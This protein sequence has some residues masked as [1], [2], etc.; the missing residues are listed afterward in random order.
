M[1]TAVASF[2]LV[3]T[4]CAHSNNY[5]QNKLASSLRNNPTTKTTTW[6]R[7]KQLWWETV[8]PKQPHMLPHTHT[9][10]HTHSHACTHTHAHTHTH[11]HTH[12]LSLSLSLSHTHTHTHAHTHTHPNTNTHTHSHTHTHTHTQTSAV[13]M[14]WTASAKS[15]ATNAGAGVMPASSPWRYFP[16]H[17]VTKT[18]TT[19]WN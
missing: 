16:A 6:R 3:L 12:T 18:E 5:S 13:R 10:T 7:G 8:T 9:C 19:N 15:L 1:A 4:S 14:C 2:Q 11:T 17:T